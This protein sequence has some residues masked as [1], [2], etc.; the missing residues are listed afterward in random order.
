MNSKESLL[1]WLSNHERMLADDQS[2]GMGTKLNT[3]DLLTHDLRTA[4]VM[5]KNIGLVLISC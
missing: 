3:V 5:D 2:I 1:S 4:V